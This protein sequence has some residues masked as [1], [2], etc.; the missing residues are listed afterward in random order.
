MKVA[1]VLKGYPR[2]SET[3][4]A[5]ELHALE[6]A[7][8]TLIIYSLRYPTDPDVHEIHRKIVAP[9]EYLSE[10]LYKEPLRVLKGLLHALGRPGI[11][12]L[13]GVFLRDLVRDF[14][15]NRVRRLGQAM[16]MARE[17]PPDVGWIY[18][19]FLHT[20]A[21]VARYC[22]ILT[23]LPWSCSAH[24]KDI[25]TSPKWELR[26]KID[27]LAWLVTC[28]QAN[29]DYL[30]GLANSPH[31]ISLLYHGLDLHR[32][33]KTQPEPVATEGSLRLLSVGR[34]VPKKGY[35]KLLEALEKLPDNLSWQFTHI[36]GGPELGSLK[37]QA[38]ILDIDKQIQWLGAQNSSEVL[39]A[40]RNADVFLLFSTV[41][42]S[43]DR[44]GLPNVIMEAM[45]QGL[46]CVAS[47]I[48]GIPEA[49]EHGVNGFMV[50][51]GDVEGLVAIIKNVAGDPALRSRI[52]SA[53][54]ETIHS[55]FS[56]E[57]NVTS[58]IERFRRV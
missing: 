46:V 16:E 7:G 42:A 22:A 49:I 40:Y 10:Y 51:D 34:A 5:Q 25:W 19:H 55:R 2:L 18:A 48:S 28:T 32:F 44:D 27:E 23:G 53:A 41:D 38:K 30:R 50:E 29:T 4:I 24:A 14:S 12:R 43:G 26:E 56:L 45:S 39:D 13:L 33:A 31:K 52:G 20:P 57:Q 15:A 11:W 21:S 1:C 8:V 37:D 9:V 36:G 6:G 17:L 54:I 58:L 35:G 3:F 47:N